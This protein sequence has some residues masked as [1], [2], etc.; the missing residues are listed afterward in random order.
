M[1][2]LFLVSNLPRLY[3]IVRRCGRPGFQLPLLLSFSHS[4]PL[5]RS[6]SSSSPTARREL[7][8]RVA[9]RAIPSSSTRRLWLY[10]DLRT[11]RGATAAAA[12]AA[13]VAAAAAAPR[14]DDVHS[15]RTTHTTGKMAAALRSFVLRFRRNGDTIA[16]VCVV[17]CRCA[18]CALALVLSPSLLHS[19]PLDR[20]SRL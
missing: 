9:G 19:R 10:R 11:T 5:S 7:L 14:K 18:T 17:C 6:S 8:P 3:I 1:H 16:V 15:T 20:N 2:H 13:A 4:L 12:A